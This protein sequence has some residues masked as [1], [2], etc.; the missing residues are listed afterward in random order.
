MYLFSLSFPSERD[1]LLFAALLKAV[2]YQPLHNIV[3]AE[4]YKEYMSEQFE[5]GIDLYAE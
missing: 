2:G 3:C 5:G 1:T 4:C